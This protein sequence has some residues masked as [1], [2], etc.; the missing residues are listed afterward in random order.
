[1]EGRITLA[2]AQ[3]VLR[4]PPG[5]PV[6]HSEQDRRRPPVAFRIGTLCRG[7]SDDR[8]RG[9]AHESVKPGPKIRSDFLPESRLARFDQLL[10]FGEAAAKVEVHDLDLGDGLPQLAL[11]VFHRL[12]DLLTLPNSLDSL[13]LLPEA[14][15]FL[16]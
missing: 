12:L 3:D 5:V 7:P 2:L 1:M 6:G 13:Q 15:I 10:P 16:A 11:H 4:L 8:Q 9:A 14:V